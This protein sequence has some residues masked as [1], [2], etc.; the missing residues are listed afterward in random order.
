MKVIDLNYYI[1]DQ[2]FKSPI[3]TP[4]IHLNTRKAL[5][6]EFK[7]ANGESYFGECNAF[8]T[9]WYDSETID[10]VKQT[11]ENWSSQIIN[12][13]FNHFEDWKP[14]LNQLNDTPSARATVC[15]A[16][17]QMYHQLD[18]FRVKY[19]ATVSGL[20]AAQIH[21]LEQTRP[22]RIKVKW[23]D[24]I[25]DDLKVLQ[26]S[27][28]FKFD[29][30]LD[31]NESLTKQNI[32]TLQKIKDYK[33][34]YVEEPFKELEYLKKLNENEIPAI[35]IDEKAA[36]F[37]TIQSICKLYPI[38]VVVLKPFRLGG[39]D[40]TLDM[41]HLL[42]T[43]NIRVVIGGM[44]EYG[45]SRYFT[46][47]LAQYSDYPGDI[48]PEGYYFERDF[49]NNSGILKEGMIKF[50]PPKVNVDDLHLLN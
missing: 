49:V 48:T 15:M 1:Y 40:K 31:A 42:K 9:D 45:L 26:E 3:V 22:Q 11:I 16:I 12:K 27:L 44:Y 30:V 4:K 37:Q 6:I 43:H 17:F 47:F 13:K 35:A 20:N 50:I 41:I 33:P 25:I 19:G 2:S 14:F 24:H 46:A 21:Q 23:T 29:L 38:K 39:I 28:S 5:V 10:S 18:E 32:G 36:S 8:E 34:L 7:V